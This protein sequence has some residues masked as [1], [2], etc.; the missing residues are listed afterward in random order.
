MGSTFFI[1]CKNC[2]YSNCFRT[3]I[4]FLYYPENLKN[5]GP[6]GI[7]PSIIRS[8]ETLDSEKTI[9]QIKELLI[10]KNAKIAR[11]YGHK[12]FRCAKCGELFKRFYIRLK[13]SGGS[14]EIE[15]KCPKCKGDLKPIK[16]KPFDDS[17]D[18]ETCPCPKCGQLSLYKGE[19]IKCW[20]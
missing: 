10:E 13:Y 19:T 15:Y 11:G 4:G 1:H 7:L 18:L 16:D 3:G 12:I 6:D 17:G 8:E 2:G 5:F 20:D 14:F 9:N